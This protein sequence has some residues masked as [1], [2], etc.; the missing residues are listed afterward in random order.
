MD[1]WTNNEYYTQ[2][3]EAV[4]KYGAVSIIGAQARALSNLYCGNISHAEALSWLLTGDKPRSIINYKS[5]SEKRD[6]R[7]RL[8]LN[9]IYDIDVR[10]SVLASIN[11]SMHVHNLTYIYN[12]QLDSHKYSRVRILTK[13]LWDYIH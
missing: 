5:E 4:G 12:S 8:W 2:V 11:S 3:C 13:L 7:I 9:D 6:E 10:N 1:Y